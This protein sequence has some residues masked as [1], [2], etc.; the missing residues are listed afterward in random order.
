MMTL[1]S[2]YTTNLCKCLLLCV[3]VTPLSHCYIGDIHGA[4][5]SEQSSL[6]D[7]YYN[8]RHFGPETFLQPKLVYWRRSP[9]WNIYRNRV[10]IVT[11]GEAAL[12]IWVNMCCVLLIHVCTYSHAH[13]NPHQHRSPLRSRSSVSRLSTSSGS[14]SSLTQDDTFAVDDMEISHM[15]EVETVETQPSFGP[16][17]SSKFYF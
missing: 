4:N 3:Y 6:A 7:N 10:L 15:E 16:A 2:G 1:T 9:D 5:L 11:T 14:S 12:A 8:S 13:P 17:V